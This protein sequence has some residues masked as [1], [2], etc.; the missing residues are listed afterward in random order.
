MP[1]NIELDMNTTTAK[2]FLRSCAVSLPHMGRFWR[3]RE[4][5]ATWPQSSI[6]IMSAVFS[7]VVA[8]VGP[9]NVN[10][11]TPAN[12]F[13]Y[14]RTTA[15]T[16]EPESGRVSTQTEHPTNAP[17]CVQTVFGYD[18]HGNRNATTTQNCA[19]AS[20]SA[21]FVSQGSSAQFSG[22]ANQTITVGNNAGVVSNV[23]VSYPPGL[24]PSASSNGLH[25]QSFRHDPRFGVAL[26]ITGPDGLTSTVT[27]DDFGRPTRIMA[28]DGTSTVTFY[29]VL[30]GTG[31][32][33]SSNSAECPAPSADEVP[34]GAA[35]FIQ[36]EPRGTNGSK[37]GAFSRA[38]IDRLGRPIRTVSE[39]FDGVDQPGGRSGALVAR[40]AVYSATG[41]KV[42]E[43]QP[44]FL[45]SISSTL[46][47]TYDVGASFTSY[48]VL[49]RATSVYVKDPSG[50]AGPKLFGLNSDHVL[51]SG[52]SGV[53]N[54]GCYGSQPAAL[55][56]YAYDGLLTT[57]TNDKGHTRTEEKNAL[58]VAIRVTDATGAQ[59]AYQ[60]DAYG[61][62]TATKDAL[63]NIV[64]ATYDV[65][66]RKVVL[67]DP[68]AGTVS[69]C[70]NAI[71]QL[72]A[73]QNSNMRGSHV[74]VAC[75]AQTSSG[76]EATPEPSWATFA[77]DQLGRLRE[78]NEPEY[79][80]T[81]TYDRYANGSACTRGVG[82]LCEV[83]TTNGTRRKLVFDSLGRPIN[84]VQ[85][86]SDGP[87]LASAVSYDAIT[88]RVASQTYPTGLRIG[89]SY[90]PR[91]YLERLKLL[92]AATVSP[93]PA[94]NGNVAASVILPAES[95]LWR[96]QL[97]NAW[98]TVERASYGNGVISN[99]TY[100]AA[101]GR[102]VDLTAGVGSATSVL[103]YHYS[104]DSLNN[105]TARSDANGDGGS[106]AVSET[107]VYGD[108]LNRLTSYTVAAPAIPGLSRTVDMRYN[109]LGMLLYKSDVGYYNYSAQGPG[110]VKPHALQS[111][112]GSV[113]VTN[114]FDA[115]GNL[116]SAA[117]G[118]YR[119]VAYTS[120]N[121]PDSQSG[122]SGPVGTPRYTWVYDDAHARV[123]EVRVTAAGT[124]TTRY[125]HPDNVGSLGFEREENTNGG[126]SNRHFLMAGGQTVGAL[127]ST[128]A[129]P[130]LNGGVL[131][132][133]P[134][135]TQAS[136]SKVEYWHKD[137]LG[138]LAATTDHAANV[139]ARYAYDPFGKRRYTNG[140]YDAN[141][142]LIVTWSSTSNAGTSRGFTGHEELD[143][144]GLVHMNGR[145]FDPTVGVFL[146]AD[147]LVT[148][149]Q[150]L[151]DFNRYSYCL[152]NPL[153]CTDPSG[154]TEDG[155]Q[156]DGSFR[157]TI[158]CWVGGQ[159]MCGPQ[160]AQYGLG[161][162]GY[163][164]G[165]FAGSGSGG[166]GGSGIYFTPVTMPAY[167]QGNS[168]SA[169]ISA[170]VV[171]FSTQTGG[172]FTIPGWD[173]YSMMS[174][175]DAQMAAISSQMNAQM[176]A[177]MA[178]GAAALAA[179]QA[180]ERMGPRNT[181]VPATSAATSGS[182]SG[183]AGWV[184]GGLTV[185]S[186]A[187]SA[188][189]SVFSLLDG[190]VYAYQGDYT[191]A[192]ISVVAAGVGLFSDAGAAKAAMM[193]AREAAG[194]R[195]AINGCCCFA[196]GTPVLTADGTKPIEEI[197]EGDLVQS[198]DPITGATSLKPVTQLI[199][200]EGKALFRLTLRNASG[201]LDVIEVTDNHPY[202][203]HGKGWIDSSKLKP[204]MR[205][206]SF[207]KK[208]LTVVS[209]QPLGR[210]EKTYNF[211]VA[212]YHTYFAG[213]SNAFVH[214]CACA[215]AIG[216]VASAA[217]YRSLFTRAR[218]DLPKGWEVHHS[219]P[220]MYEELM[221]V[222]GLN[223]H[224]VQF[225]RGVSPQI[226]SKIT[227]EW[228]HFHKAAGGNPSATQ[229]ADF[230]KQ[231]DRKYGGNF[232][233]PGF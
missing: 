216:E 122:V 217:N 88:G 232:M 74:P 99:S 105:L 59:I 68:D 193:G 38:Y 137:H 49:G 196:A 120:F 31:S 55:T 16:Y 70:Y 161:D 214:N 172:A 98:G 48:D 90:T 145:I 211:T 41:F 44:F 11:Q 182:W 111:V 213:A 65:A 129:L 224:E 158:V 222:A 207:Q 112:W 60:F 52:Y 133:P 6:A 146:Q 53:G 36:S 215:K 140:R 183:A 35:M 126:S 138:S 89:Y 132:A 123:K 147:P 115:N 57:V 194:A 20:T 225:L 144:V 29:C 58:G 230:A 155:Y 15:F 159:N 233:W 202:W 199:H 100:Q 231:L 92:T 113:N 12:P 170:S 156:P 107:F 177:E 109:A 179:Q 187:P 10:A 78:R 227:T 150:D 219:M 212:D 72:T 204:G 166:V 189:G 97:V 77:Y 118:K 157:L 93:L 14:S 82:K 84:S 142:E 192:G 104:W 50:L 169:S 121:L 114:R 62:L 168:Y 149:P 223:I 83:S 67:T 160:P 37:I 71:G 119:N 76:S 148:S 108:S 220:Q 33:L 210:V 198:R 206:D 116:T 106:G 117:S 195:A 152:N 34:A 128:T 165:G 208:R 95:T 190:A 21:S 229:V 22:V 164:Q 103:N 191:S 17:S 221:R 39:S 32:D 127:V 135:L 200:T 201:Q 26:Q 85:S 181:V 40:D 28:P 163:G 75:P 24:F 66:G 4:S 171:A 56:R 51:C 124:R 5:R 18:A 86:G 174:Q 73:R 134:E 203:V 101:T 7:A 9:V 205:L 3:K 54:Y 1:I 125:M 185:A 30:S 42:I 153:T 186:F 173:Y 110:S 87:P 180:Y 178:A 94:P 64:S 176:Q 136:L 218:P 184:H 131:T 167:T 188:I 154:L 143:D 81:W 23:L 151:Q 197:R 63:Q 43:T 79:K 96:A 2:R 175:F 80:T 47:G 27:V 19:G 226:H 209:L 46:N 91:G 139:T 8:L 69:Y 102:A 141:G 162:G 45:S 61:A 130:D 13:N 228:T 25:E